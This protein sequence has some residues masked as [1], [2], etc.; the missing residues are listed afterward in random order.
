M[1]EYVSATRAQARRRRRVEAE[2][3]SIVRRLDWI[4]LAATGGIVAFGLWVISG[5]TRTDVAGNP[6]YYVVRQ[7]VFIAIGLVGLV[8]AV[9]IDPAVYKRYKRPIYAGTLGL[10]AIVFLGGTVARGSK[11]WIDL[12][13]FRFQPSE[14]GKLLFVLFLA[15]FL[16]DRGKRIGEIGVAAAAIGLALAPVLLVF[17]EP[18]VGTALVYFAAL[19]AVLFVAGVRWLHLAAVGAIA[20]TVALAVLWWLPAAGL[21][22]LKPYQQQRLT[23]FLHSSSDSQGT[24]YNQTQSEIAVGAG[25][26]R[27]RGV[28]GATQTNLDYLPEHATD[29]AFASLAE[30]RGFVGAGLL[31]LL[32]LLV[33]WRGLKIVTAARDPFSAVVAGGIVSTL[34]FQV[35]VNAGMTIRIAPITGIPLPM[36]S[37]GGSSMVANL[38]AIGV[39]QAIHV[40]GRRHGLR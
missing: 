34:L 26:L 37:V 24:T 33:V 16:A 20:L 35:F 15:G 12:G 19:A 11:R 31:L 38:A 6:H 8:A 13:F 10:M 39:L 25:G 14:F 21:P 22:V 36:V 2:A 9:L 3:T 4:L 40:R 28:H 7:G 5:V 17:V 30:Q 29:F 23:A 27:G 18:D 32:Y 1:A